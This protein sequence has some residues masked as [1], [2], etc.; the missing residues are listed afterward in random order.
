MVASLLAH[1]GADADGHADAAHHQRHEPG[2]PEVHGELRPEPPEPGLGLGIGDDADGRVGE[3]QGKRV[4][5]DLRISS[6]GQ[7]D[8]R[9]IPDAAARP[10]EAGAVQILVGDQDSR[11]EGEDAERRDR[12]PG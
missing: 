1:E 10:H 11:P 7:P 12:V 3:P 5:Q 4:A 6:I 9:A 8:E 2:Q